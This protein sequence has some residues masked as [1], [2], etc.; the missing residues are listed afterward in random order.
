MFGIPR[1][2]WAVL[3]LEALTAVPTAAMPAF[4]GF[5]MNQF[6][7]SAALAGRVAAVE[8]LGMA[9][10]QLISAV[11]LAR[12]GVNLRRAA[13]AALLVFAL[14]QL[15]SLWPNITGLFG[16][17]RLLSGVSGGGLMCAIAGLYVAR[18]PNPDRGYSLFYG[19]LFVVGPLGIFVLPH[20]FASNHPS[21][22][23]VVLSITAFLALPILR[24]LPAVR[25]EPPDAERHAAMS[26]TWTR[27]VVGLLLAGMFANYLANGGVW[28]YMEPIGHAFALRSET[29]GLYLAIGMATGL[30]GTAAAIAASGRVKRLHATLLGGGLLIAGFLVLLIS[31]SPQHFL[32]GAMLQN[33]AVTFLS[34]F[35]LAALARTDSAG[36][37]ATIGIFT[38][39]LGYGTGPAF[40]SLFVTTDF[41]TLLLVA[42]GTAFLSMVLFSVAAMIE[43]RR[44]PSCESMVLT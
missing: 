17:A 43:R 14:A 25:P 42:S 12:S 28:I 35:V 31:T 5:Y 10:G 33:V 32:A 4:I 30:L 21:V 34:P 24:A 13:L 16:F 11:W 7:Y 18:L 9:V 39:M 40:L 15:L 3:T 27:W 23:Y 29:I 36:R 20:V 38:F 22:V 26:H 6:G 2:L 19:T 41:H 8:A 1:Q 44:A 37:N